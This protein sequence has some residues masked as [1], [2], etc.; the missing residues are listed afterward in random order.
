MLL[1]KGN[2]NCCRDMLAAVIAMER[3]IEMLK[4]M[5]SSL[6]GRVRVPPPA[7]AGTER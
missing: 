3:S 1:A 5:R 6:D 2:S 7:Q 4:S